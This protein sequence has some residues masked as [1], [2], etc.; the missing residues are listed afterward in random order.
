MAESVAHRLQ[1][2]L[3]RPEAHRLVRR[4]ALRAAEQRVTFREALLAEPAV[5]AHLSEQEI[6]AALDPAAY[7]GSAGELVDRALEAH[8]ALEIPR[9]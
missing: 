3:G 1:G 7:L 8:R 2:A 6:D 5:R 9:G 4:C